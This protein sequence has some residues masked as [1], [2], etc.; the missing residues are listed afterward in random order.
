M[1]GLWRLSGVLRL[2]VRRLRLLGLPWVLRL[3]GLPRL[4]RLLG[5]R[6]LGWLLRLLRWHGSGPGLHRSGCSAHGGGEPQPGHGGRE[7]AG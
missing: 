6:L 5:L 7:S 4:L 1:L 2:L 3:L